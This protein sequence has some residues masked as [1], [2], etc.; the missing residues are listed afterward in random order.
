[1]AL[2]TALIFHQAAA[3]MAA[4]AKSAEARAAAAKAA[5]EK[6]AEAKAAEAKVAAEA[7]ALSA[8]KH[9]RWVTNGV[10]ESVTMGTVS[11]FRLRSWPAR[12]ACPTQCNSVSLVVFWQFCLSSF[13]SALPTNQWF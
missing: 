3:A 9:A 12:P 2:L 4:E 10:R 5:E 7:E 1:M 6:A 11:V 13:C 8:H